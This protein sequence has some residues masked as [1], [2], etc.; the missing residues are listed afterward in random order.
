MLSYFEKAISS[1]FSS[2]PSVTFFIYARDFSVQAIQPG[3]G[4]QRSSYSMVKLGGKQ[5]EREADQ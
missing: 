2:Q 1:P 4:T 3:S 5:L